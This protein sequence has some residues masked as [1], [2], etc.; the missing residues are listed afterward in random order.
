M[1]T[2]M[3]LC[4]YLEQV[5]GE[6]YCVYWDLSLRGN[7]DL[8]CYPSGWDC[9][10]EPG[11]CIFEGRWMTITEYEEYLQ[12]KSE[13]ELPEGYEC[14]EFRLNR[15]GLVELLLP[16]RRV[17]VESMTGEVHYLKMKPEYPRI[18]KT[19]AFAL[20]RY[21]TEVK[22]HSLARPGAP[23]WVASLRI[24]D[25]PCRVEL[26]VVLKE[27]RLDFVEGYC[28]HGE[29][30]PKVDE[31]KRAILTSEAFSPLWQDLLRELFNRMAADFNSP[32]P[33]TPETVVTRSEDDADLWPYDFEKSL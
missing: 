24:V 11:G 8:R 13:R 32:G 6:L 18:V 4:R 12:H 5:D 23:Q 15:E 27:T 7:E 20:I 3:K 25:G 2:N 22:P 17:P 30:C 9:Y 33:L 21:E 16:Q 14:Q 31:L 1:G 26:A 19:V 28:S 10:E 29:L